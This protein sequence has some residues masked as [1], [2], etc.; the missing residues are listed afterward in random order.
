MMQHGFVA[1]VKI[2]TRMVLVK[3][4]TRF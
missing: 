4:K 2:R 1:G 3:L